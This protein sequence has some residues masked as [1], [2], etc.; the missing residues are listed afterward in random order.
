MQGWHSKSKFGSKIDDLSI[1][2]TIL[3]LCSALNLALD[4]KKPAG[5]VEIA[6]GSVQYVLSSELTGYNEL[7]QVVH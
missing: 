4:L 3:F 7:E 5:H 2:D 1:V 6:E